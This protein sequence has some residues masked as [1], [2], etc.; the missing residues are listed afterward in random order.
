ME[1]HVDI[2]KSLKSLLGSGSLITLIGAHDALS[3]KIAEQSNFD[4]IWAS[5]LGMSATM[6]LRDANE[7]SWTEVL[8]VVERISDAVDLPVL[9]DA[10]TGF[11]NFNNARR[12]TRK[13]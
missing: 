7:A 2:R 10:D 9:L 5:G 6:L 4:G 13:L 1:A 12:L 11:G 8:Q 3:A